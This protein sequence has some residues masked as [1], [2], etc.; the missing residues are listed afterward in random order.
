MVDN[1]K[2]YAN[3]TLS[4]SQLMVGSKV[5]ITTTLRRTIAQALML[6]KVRK[7]LNQSSDIT[8]KDDVI[9]GPNDEIFAQ[10]DTAVWEG[11]EIDKRSFNFDQLT[12]LPDDMIGYYVEDAFIEYLASQDNW[13]HLGSFDRVVGNLV[14]QDEEEMY[15]NT[16][17]VDVYQSIDQVHNV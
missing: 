13:Q 12:S 6:A 2:I 9:Y 4:R 7:S 15:D 11:L 17:A 10:S 1:R 16:D 14:R 8:V 5:A 3:G